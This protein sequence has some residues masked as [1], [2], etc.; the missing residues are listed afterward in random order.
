VKKT[1]LILVLVLVPACVTPREKKFWEAMNAYVYGPGE[2]WMQRDEADP[3]V[4]EVSKKIRRE[5]HEKAKEACRN[6]GIAIGAVES[7]S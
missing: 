2:I 1:L 6:E 3:N 4:P 7:G 5:T